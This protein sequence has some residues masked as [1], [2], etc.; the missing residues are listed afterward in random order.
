MNPFD[1]RGPEFLL[2]YVVFAILVIVGAWLFR[3]MKEVG[4]AP[5]MEL[6]PYAIAYLRGGKNE[7]VRV[8]MVSLID[9]G[10]L[11]A[12]AD[13]VVRASHADPSSVRR[14]I[15]KALLEK[16]AARRKA[17]DIFKETSLEAACS[18]FQNTLKEHALLPDGGAGP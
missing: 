1:L 6:D 7:A 16:F 3:R 10:L 11:I 8:A 15:E 14:P 12:N 5:K 13:Q 18:P 2:F 17:P 9:R 4:P